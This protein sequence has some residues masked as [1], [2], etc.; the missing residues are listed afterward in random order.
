[1]R[2][3]MKTFKI[4]SVFILLSVLTHPVQAQT[5]GDIPI[6]VNK[7]TDRVILIK[8]GE[9]SVLTN[10]LAISTER[11]IVV[12]DATW[13]PGLARRV[14]TIIEKEFGRKDFAYLILTHAGFDH[15]S[16]NQVFTEATIIGH[17]IVPSRMQ[18][19]IGR[20]REAGTFFNTAFQNAKKALQNV[21]K[22]SQEEKERTEFVNSYTILLNET[23]SQDFIITPPD[24]TFS[25]RLNLCFADLT[26]RMRHNIESYSD[27]DIITYIPELKILNVGDIF[28][29][30]RLPWISPRSDI[31][32]WLEIFKEFTDK[33]KEIDYVIGGHGGLMTMAE[34]EEFLNY[35]G[36]LWEGLK[37]AKKEGLTLNDIQEK[38]SFENFNHVTHINPIIPGWGIDM[39][40][41]NVRN[42]WRMLEN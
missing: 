12:F 28:N 15:T 3:E 34:V 40:R 5:A 29:N 10:V 19:N 37:T 41:M 25:D 1:M 7:L 11:G 8:T 32:Q 39:H 27:N 26:L 36:D 17:D 31:P 30:D 6:E 22:G 2:E 42:I 20:I 14:K 18:A 38:F 24:I 4:F 33:E 9:T 21:A 13:L 16:G 23:S 35:V